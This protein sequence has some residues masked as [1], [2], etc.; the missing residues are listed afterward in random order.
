MILKADGSTKLITGREGALRS[1][2]GP[3]FPMPK[4]WFQAADTVGCPS[5]GPAGPPRRFSHIR[6]SL[7]TVLPQTKWQCI[8]G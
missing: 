5:L 6:T 8:F 2:R 1:P 3:T 7:A 4:V